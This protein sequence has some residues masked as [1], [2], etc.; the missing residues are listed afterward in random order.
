MVRSEIPLKS[1]SHIRTNPQMPVKWSNYIVAIY[2]EMPCL[3][4]LP[5]VVTFLSELN[6]VAHFEHVRTNGKFRIASA[7]GFSIARIAQ[8]Y[9]CRLSITKYTHPL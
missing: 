1:F 4:C 2:Y 3:V 5:R 7:E 8:E 9:K 6:R